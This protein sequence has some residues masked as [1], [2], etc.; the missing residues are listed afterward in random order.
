MV[1]ILLISSGIAI[2]YGKASS[3]LI[4]LLLG[5]SG[6]LCQLFLI[7]VIVFFVYSDHATSRGHGKRSHDRI[8][9]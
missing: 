4:G 6:M 2:I 8:L 1:L 3:Y 9:F 5:G 7:L